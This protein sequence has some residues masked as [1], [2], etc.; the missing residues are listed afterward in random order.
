MQLPGT[1]STCGSVGQP[2]VGE[3][4]LASS[5]FNRFRVSWGHGFRIWMQSPYTRVSE[6]FDFLHLSASQPRVNLARRALRFRLCEDAA[7]NPC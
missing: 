4:S 7:K 2:V 1:Q 6:F 3:R 5:G